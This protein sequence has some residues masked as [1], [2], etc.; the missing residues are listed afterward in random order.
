MIRMRMK[1]LT[2]ITGLPK[3]TIQYYI[4]EGLVP[5]PIKTQTNMAYYSEVHIDAIRLVKEL[6]SKRYLPLS[7][8][9]QIV[10]NDRNGLSV[11]EIQTIAKLDG[12]LCKNL[13]KGVKIKKITVKQL[14]S[15]TGAQL[16][17]IKELERMGILHPLKMEKQ[18]Y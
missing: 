16:S 2:A 9:K 12:K 10:K 7:V 4:N 8:I 5:P 15:R 1:E 6:Q 17:E 18:Q 13:V 3:G 14:V 11:N